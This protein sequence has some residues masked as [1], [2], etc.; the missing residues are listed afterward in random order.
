MD[1]ARVF[2]M[3]PS[4]LLLE[5]DRTRPPPR[6]AARPVA[7]RTVGPP[8]E[9]ESTAIAGSPRG[10]YATVPPVPDPPEPGGP[11]LPEPGPLP[12]DPVPDP[13]DP[14]PGPGPGPLPPEPEPQPEPA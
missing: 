10:M 2:L 1:T 5:T 6:I 11:P 13:P 3:V 9:V 14:E 4:C 12:P 7:P 8:A